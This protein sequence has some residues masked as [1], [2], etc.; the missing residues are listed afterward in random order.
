MSAPTEINPAAPKRPRRAAKPQPVPAAELCAD[1]VRLLRLFSAM[2]QTRQGHLVIVA[3]GFAEGFPRA[4]APPL[5][6]IVG[7]IR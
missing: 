2:D 6:L 4:A 1:Q 3:E 7:G 5:R